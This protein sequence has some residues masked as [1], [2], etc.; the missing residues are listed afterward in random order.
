MFD[1]C[2]GIPHWPGQDP[3]TSVSQSE[4]SPI[5]L[6]L[7]VSFHICRPAPLSIDASCLL[8]VPPPL[9]F[10]DTSPNRSLVH[11]SSSWFLI[12]RGPKLTHR[13]IFF[14]SSVAS[15]TLDWISVVPSSSKILPAFVILELSL[16]DERKKR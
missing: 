8:L 15:R 13:L 1:L 11:L 10:T 3:F 7:S 14:L 16:F 12:F 2:S 9:P 6:L 5:H 4:G